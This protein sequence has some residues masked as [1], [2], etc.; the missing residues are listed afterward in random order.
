MFCL[1]SEWG[2]SELPVAPHITE[3]M[4]ELP[5]PVASPHTWHVSSKCSPGAG[6]APSVVLTPG[7]PSR[8]S[9]D[10][11]PRGEPAQDTLPQARVGAIPELLIDPFWEDPAS[12]FTFLKPRRP[13]QAAALRVRMGSCPHPQPQDGVPWTVGLRWG[14]GREAPCRPELLISGYPPSPQGL[15]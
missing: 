3:A 13:V 8:A 14:W 12:D 11:S 4:S 10:R 9:A 5:E 2:G 1:C 7:C 6:V 15:L